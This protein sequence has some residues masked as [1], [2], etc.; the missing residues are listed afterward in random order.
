MHIV[1]QSSHVNGTHILVT[2]SVKYKKLWPKTVSTSNNVNLLLTLERT[3][4][5][6]KSFQRLTTLEKKKKKHVTAVVIMH[7]SKLN[8]VSASNNALHWQ[9]PVV[10]PNY[11]HA[12]EP[13][14]TSLV[15]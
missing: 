9:V 15:L 3:R 7:R 14:F 5:H 6:L 4:K 8:A 1:R 11:K 10:K 2:E 13:A 12:L